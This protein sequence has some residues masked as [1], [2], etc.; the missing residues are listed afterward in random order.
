MAE[1][2][3]KKRYLSHHDIVLPLQKSWPKRYSVELMVNILMNNPIFIFQNQMKCQ[4]SKTKKKSVLQRK[5]DMQIAREGNFQ[6]KL[7]K[8]VLLRSH[9]SIHGFVWNH[10]LD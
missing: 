9:E 1:G 4:N 5:Q 10:F 6:N 2:K 3:F 8:E 7:F